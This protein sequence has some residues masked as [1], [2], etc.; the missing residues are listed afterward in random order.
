MRRRSRCL[1]MLLFFIPL[2]ACQQPVS[3]I[4]PE[5]EVTFIEIVK[6]DTLEHV[7]YFDDL[8]LIRKLVR[9]LDRAETMSIS[10]RNIAVPE[11]KLLFFE[12]EKGTK[13][14]ELGYYLEVMNIGLSGRF[15]DE[16]SE[17]ILGVKIRLPIE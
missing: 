11:Y 3:L 15:L 14:Y 1:L 17:G 2:V 4:S 6:W 12:K 7:G 8:A 10:N 9:E 13:I 5:T 16:K